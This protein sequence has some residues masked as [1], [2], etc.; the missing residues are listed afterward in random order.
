MFFGC[1][2]HS[3]G[4]LSSPKGRTSPPAVEA[5]SRNRWTSREIPSAGPPTRHA[6]SLGHRFLICQVNR[7][8]SEVLTGAEH[9]TC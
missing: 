4:D 6:P 3:L 1:T 5:Q 2:T 7:M 8:V 9:P